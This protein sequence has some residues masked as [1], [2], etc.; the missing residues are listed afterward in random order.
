MFLSNGKAE[1]GI[2]LFAF[3][4]SF[5]MAYIPLYLKSSLIQIETD[6]IYFLAKGV[7]FWLPHLSTQSA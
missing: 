3:S 7:H 2:F 4:Y 1:A 5:K 6:C